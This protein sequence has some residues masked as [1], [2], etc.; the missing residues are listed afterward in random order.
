MVAVSVKAEKGIGMEGPLA[1]WYAGTTRKSLGEFQALARRIAG[2]LAPGSRVLE[3]APGPGYFA[4]ELARLGNY[5]VTGLDISRTFVDIARRNAADALVAVD[6]QQGNVAGMPFESGR[7]D[8][9]LCRAAFKNFAE[10]VLA[11]REMHRVLVPG[12]KAV[13]IDLRRDT[14]MESIRKAVSQMGLGLINR[15]ITKFI[16]RTMLLKRA[17]TK[18]QFES[19]LSQTDFQTVHFREGLIDIEIEME[20]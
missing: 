20:K 1:R 12:G 17:Y 5:R 3:V 10:P 6:F 16:F 9:L 18:G 14:S 15:T 19:F 13:I 11:L 2:Q 8:F 4:V 7:F